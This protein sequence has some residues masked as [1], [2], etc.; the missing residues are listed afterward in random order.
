MYADQANINRRCSRNTKS[1]DFAAP[2]FQV[3]K[4]LGRDHSV[5][6]SSAP[7]ARRRA[8]APRRHGGPGTATIAAVC[9]TGII[10]AASRSPAPADVGLRRRVRNAKRFAR[11]LNPDGGRGTATRAYKESV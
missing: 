5:G 1:P 10:A 9:E 7:V 3:P 2:V 4:T 11:C 6:R 8:D